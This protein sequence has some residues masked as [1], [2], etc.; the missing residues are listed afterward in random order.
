[1][2]QENLKDLRIQINSEEF[3]AEDSYGLSDLCVKLFG[4]KIKKGTLA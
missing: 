1:M 4:K 3:I 2:T